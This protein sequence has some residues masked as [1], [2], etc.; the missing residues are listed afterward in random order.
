MDKITYHKEGDY[1]I[2]DI[3]LEKQERINLGRYARARLNHMK[4]H[5]RVL[6]D[7]LLING[8]LSNYLKDIDKQCSQI[9]RAT[10]EEMAK[11]NHID[12]K[13]KARDQMKWIGLMNNFKNA[14]EE[15]V[16]SKFIYV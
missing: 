5:K 2:P 12:E 15:I 9:V 7:K 1:L 14:A 6:Y 3:V 13:L 8:S 4:E 10:I 11:E 16:F